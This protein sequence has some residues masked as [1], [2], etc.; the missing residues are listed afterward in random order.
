MSLTKDDL[1]QIKNIVSQEFVLAFEHIVIP[2]VDAKIDELRREIKG[3][4]NE[5]FADVHQR[6]DEVIALNAKYYQ[7]CASKNL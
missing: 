1:Q 6:F 5:R 2:Y 7:D 4:M 3:E